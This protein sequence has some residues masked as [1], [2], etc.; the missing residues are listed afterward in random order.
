MF[1]ATRTPTVRTEGD[2]HRLDLRGPE[3]GDDLAVPRECRVQ[4]A[5]GA[6][7]QHRH[8]TL[9]GHHA[10]AD[11]DDAAVRLDRDIGYAV[12][13]VRADVRLHL[14][15]VAEGLIRCPVRVE[16]GHADVVADIPDH[17][18]PA[19]QVD[20]HRRGSLGER[21]CAELDDGLAVIAEAGVGRAGGRE[22]RD[23]HVGGGRRAR[24]AADHH[25]PVVDGNDVVALGIIEVR[26]GAPALAVGRRVQGVAVPVRQQPQDLHRRFFGG[27]DR[28][29]QQ[30]PA[31]RVDRHAVGHVL[32]LRVEAEDRVLRR[33]PEPER[34]IGC[35][36]REDPRQDDVAFSDQRR[37]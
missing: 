25:G 16:P 21:R 11:H 4:D 34:R 5:V 18:D 31:G 1:T 19:V 15:V 7:A 3:A 13:R 29:G 2:A 23:R 24:P 35:A 26:L 9:T 8:A 12:H 36:R 14:A 20:R 22:L 28:P 30:E 27:V 32:R 33:A 6:V 17:D 37:G 10:C